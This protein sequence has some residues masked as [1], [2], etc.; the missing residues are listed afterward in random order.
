MA[1]G[2]YCTDPI[3]VC[4]YLFPPA[5]SDDFVSGGFVGAAGLEIPGA[6]ASLDSFAAVGVMVFMGT[7]GWGIVAIFCVCVPSILRT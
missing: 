4:F 5:G 3:P 7:F 6:V 2:F 1:A